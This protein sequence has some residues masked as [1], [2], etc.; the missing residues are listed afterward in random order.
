M[1]NISLIGAPIDTGQKVAGC[2]MGPSALRVAGLHGVLADLGH[3]VQDL[4][5]VH[6]QVAPFKLPKP[7]SASSQRNPRLDQSA[8]KG[9][10]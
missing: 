9:L 3:H 4:G 2:L 1:T 10:F 7:S 5:N 6:G 8:G